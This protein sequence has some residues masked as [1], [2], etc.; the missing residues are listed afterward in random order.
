[1]EILNITYDYDISPA[2]HEFMLL[3]ESEVCLEEKQTNNLAAPINCN[4]SAILCTFLKLL[5]EEG[6]VQPKGEIT[7]EIFLTCSL[8]V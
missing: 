1:M 4:T 5:Q 3:I 2:S 6:F 7:S 8:F